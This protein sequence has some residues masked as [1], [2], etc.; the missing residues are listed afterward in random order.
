MVLLLPR[1]RQFIT[2][3]ASARG[4]QERNRQRATKRGQEGERDEEEREGASWSEGERDEEEN[5]VEG[6]M[7]GPPHILLGILPHSR[8][9]LVSW[10]S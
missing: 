1:I 4:C 10:E 8:D 5:G 7:G 3:M 6:I 9:I 2:I